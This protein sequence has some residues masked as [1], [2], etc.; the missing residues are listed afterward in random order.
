MAEPALFASHDDELLVRV[1]V[2]QGR[3]LDDLP[4]TDAFEA[5]VSAIAQDADRVADDERASILHRLL[6]LRKAG[7]LPRL[8]AGH[9]QRPRIEPEAEAL[10]ER[11]LREELGEGLGGRDRLPY[12]AGF[13]RVAERFAAQSG[14]TVDRHDLWRLIAK[15]AK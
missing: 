11:L 8:G 5:I 10:L 4:Y 3:T 12:T 13:D 14:L 1:Y 9:G 7:K 6:N 15:L 2:A